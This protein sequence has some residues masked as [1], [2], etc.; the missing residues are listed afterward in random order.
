MVQLTAV[1]TKMA[2][3]L[4]VLL[5]LICLLT[6]VTEGENLSLSSLLVFTFLGCLEKIIAIDVEISH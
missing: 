2:R 5:L 6:E 4:T 1:R 3:F